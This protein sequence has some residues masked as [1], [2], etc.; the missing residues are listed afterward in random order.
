[1]YRFKKEALEILLQKAAREPFKTQYY[2]DIL[3][4]TDVAKFEELLEADGTFRDLE[5]GISAIMLALKRL[6]KTTLSAFLS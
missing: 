4:G 2:K 6:A 1:M 5:D 3:K